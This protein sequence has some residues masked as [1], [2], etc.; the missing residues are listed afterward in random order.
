VSIRW[1]LF[2][3]L[4]LLTAGAIGV[5]LFVAEREFHG[6]V[7]G[8]IQERFE[9]QI[10]GLLEA[11]TERLAELRD[12]CTEIAEHPVI[13]AE[14]RGEDTRDRREAFLKEFLENRPGLSGGAGRQRQGDER[15]GP[16]RSAPNK[17]PAPG[18]R[19][20]EAP[21][22]KPLASGRGLPVMGII[23]LEGNPKD[24][25][26][27][28]QRSRARRAKA[29]RRIGELSR[30]RTQETAY[31]V[32]AGEDDRRSR[33]QEVVL[34]PVRDDDGSMLGWFFL[35]RD[36][37][38]QIERNFQQAEKY[39]GR[40][41][42]SGLV[43]EGEWLVPGVSAEE[44]EAIAAQVGEELWTDDTPERVEINGASFV[45]LARDLNPDSPLG[46]GY[47]VTLFPI[48]SLLTALDHL[49]T[50]VG[51]IGLGAV[52]ATSLV[53][54]FLARRF[55]RPIA[56]LVAGT[57]RV[58][59][60]KLDEDVRVGSKDE[61]G[62]LAKAFN[63]MTRDLALKER[64]REVLGKVSDPTVAQQL[65]EGD[66]ELGGE[67]RDAAVLFCDIRGFTAMTE[68]MDPAEVIEFVNEHMTAM[69][70]LVYLHG[71]VVDKF[72]GD[73]IMAVF[74]V[75]TSQGDDALRAARCALEMLDE[76]HRLN[77]RTGRIVE[78][79][80]GLAYGELVAGCMGSTDR[81]NYTVLGDRVN[82]AA[83]L[84][85]AAGPGELLADQAVADALDDSI[86]ATAREPIELKGFSEPM[87]S[88]ALGR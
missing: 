19:I 4:F 79:G 84:C 15:S 73:L 17:R 35:G 75:P 78:V 8:G 62:T 86:H 81:L 74:G 18:S 50:V 43:V 76:R 37:E 46:K 40:D 67:V 26:R 29:A 36:A 56:E 65:I 28:V 72:V 27:A 52:F 60:G 70:Q 31:V 41:G 34:T 88:F 83:R 22:R 87:D 14:L 77:T 11:R 7:R 54:Y 2:L 44:A 13:K 59:Q 53:A 49:R 71:G 1:K 20:R 23:D 85:S 80:I 32:L 45:V 47:Q 6:W 64:Y 38:T 82:L 9:A 5:V 30:R 66:L 39:S 58:R 3:T 57:E 55:S 25:G 61:F 68:G 12:V 33:V 24:F 48:D 69:T 51:A 42:R 16:R 10:T 21:A 63:A